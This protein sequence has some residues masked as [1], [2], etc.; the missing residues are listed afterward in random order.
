MVR[1]WVFIIL[2]RLTSRQGWHGSVKARH[3]VMALRDHFQEETSKSADGEP[4]EHPTIV[5]DE[6][7]MWALE[8]IK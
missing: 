4:R 2:L 3:F 8:Y 1:G 5:I 6:A 7:D